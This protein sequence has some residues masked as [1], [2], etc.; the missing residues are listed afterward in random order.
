LAL[1]AFFF[2]SE[3]SLAASLLIF[4][5]ACSESKIALAAVVSPVS[6]IFLAVASASSMAC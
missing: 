1:T 3:A 6:S 4:S 2:R 5:A